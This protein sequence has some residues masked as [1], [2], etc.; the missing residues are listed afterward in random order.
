MHAADVTLKRQWAQV[1]LNGLGSAS[2]AVCLGK[3][4]QMYCKA[5]RLNKLLTALLFCVTNANYHLRQLRII[6]LLELS[7][8]VLV[9]SRS[10]LYSKE[11]AQWF[12]LFAV[13]SRT[14][15]ELHESVPEAV[16]WTVFLFAVLHIVTTWCQAISI[17]LLWALDTALSMLKILEC[18]QDY[19]LYDNNVFTIKATLAASDN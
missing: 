2:S 15:F 19:E 12:V 1:F 18:Q 7:K 13:V 14:V 8:R 16:K 4:S 9:S 3:Y 10:H 6:M 17:Q 5:D 11:H